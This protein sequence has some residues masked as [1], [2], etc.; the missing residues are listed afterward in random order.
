MGHPQAHEARSN[1]DDGVQ[2]PSARGNRLND[3]TKWHTRLTE[4]FKNK[5]QHFRILGV[6]GDT[7]GATGTI[8]HT[9]VAMGTVSRT[10]A[11]NIGDRPFTLPYDLFRSP[12]V[13]ATGK[14]TAGREAPIPL[15]GGIE[16][17]ILPGR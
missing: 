13:A 8:G 10:M 4:K 14:P 17:C 6:V 5:S 1:V 11:V 7:I 9:T 3:A 15:I 16:H 2:R 12:S